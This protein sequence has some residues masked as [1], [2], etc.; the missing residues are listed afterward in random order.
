MNTRERH[1]AQCAM[2]QATRVAELAGMPS[3]CPLDRRV[4]DRSI[5]FLLHDLAALVNNANPFSPLFSDN[6]SI[7]T[8]DTGEREDDSPTDK[9]NLNDILTKLRT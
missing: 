8:G 6:D 4:L 1:L 9:L 3:N 5:K 2:K 7:S